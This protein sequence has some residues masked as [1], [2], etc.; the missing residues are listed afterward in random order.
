MQILLLDRRRYLDTINLNLSFLKD[1]KITNKDELL[2]L[3][4]KAL[5]EVNKL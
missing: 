3:N 1:S 2:S 5:E 4:K